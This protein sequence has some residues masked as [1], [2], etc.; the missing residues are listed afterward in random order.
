MDNLENPFLRAEWLL[1]GEAI[2]RLR[3]SHVAIFG[4]GGVGSYAAEALARCGVGELTL[5]DHDVVSVTNINRQIHALRS[6]I[7]KR[8]V[9][10]MRGRVLDINPEARVNALP[11]FFNEHTELNWDFDYVIDAV[12]TVTAKLQIILTAKQL[13]VPV[14]SAMG[15]G[16]KLDPTRFLAADI[17][18]TR[19]CPLAKVMRQL[20]RRYGIASLRV[21]YSTEVPREVPVSGRKMIG[22]IAFAPAAAGLALAF[23]AVNGLTGMV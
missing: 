11:V 23:E 12:D 10:V 17:Y 22:S 9:D 15:A 19:V 13:N 2:A 18:E 6:T 1:G 5:I 8:K 20:C 16:N 14:V 3:D 21:V 7:G 4:I